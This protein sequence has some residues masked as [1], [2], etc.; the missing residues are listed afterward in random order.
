MTAKNHFKIQVNLCLQISYKKH[1]ID[2]FAHPT[3]TSTKWQQQNYTVTL[4]S[5]VHTSTS[6]L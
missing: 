3:F 1:S 6:L 2:F 5:Y 4:I